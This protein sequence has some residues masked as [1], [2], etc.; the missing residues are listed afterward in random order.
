M[1]EPNI[2]GLSGLGWSF[3]P[4]C[5]LLDSSLSL[6]VAQTFLCFSVIQSF[7]SV[8]Y[9]PSW[10]LVDAIFVV[11]TIASDNQTSQL[12]GKVFAQWSVLKNSEHNNQ[13]YGII[14]HCN[15]G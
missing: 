4:E 12:L 9:T 6:Y 7:E 8:L 15:A 3:S 11:F 13:C 1:I 2:T 5:P 10:D 14:S